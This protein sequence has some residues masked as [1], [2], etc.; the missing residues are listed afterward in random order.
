[1]TL[2]KNNSPEKQTGSRFKYHFLA[3]FAYIPV[4]RILD[5]CLSFEHFGRKLVKK[6]LRIIGRR[7]KNKHS[8]PIFLFQF[9]NVLYIFM[10]VSSMKTFQGNYL[11]ST[12]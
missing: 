7:G 2:L 8:N 10:L 4:T 3:V 12:T 5:W 9:F 11:K 6:T 1:M